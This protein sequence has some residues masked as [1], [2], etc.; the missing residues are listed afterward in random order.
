MADDKQPTPD[1]D[2]PEFGPSASGADAAKDGAPPESP[3]GESA[4]EAA[5]SG[6]AGDGTAADGEKQGRRKVGRWPMAALIVL[7]LLAAGLYLSWPILQSRLSGP[8]VTPQAPEATN[9]LDRRVARLEAADARR[10]QAVGTIKSTMDAFA[11][12]L[13]EL[14]QGL[15]G[16][17]DLAV[18][19]GKLTTMEAV[20]ARLGRKAGE[21][22]AAALA[23]LGAEVNV[24]RTRLGALAGQVAR[25]GSESESDTG[26]ANARAPVSGPSQEEVTALAQQAAALASDNK[27]LRQTLASLQA[28][29]EP[30]ERAVRQSARAGPKAGASEGLVLAV[31]QLHRTV[32]AGV[33]YT[34]ALAAVTALAGDD[35]ALQQ[36]ARTLAP[37]AGRGIASL[38]ALSDQFPGLTR[39]VLGAGGEDSDDFWRRTLHRFTSLVTVRRVGEVEGMEVDA[40]L[41]RAERRLAAGDLAAAANLIDGLDGPAATAARDWLGRAQAR[42]AAMAA[43]ADLQSR[44]IAALAHG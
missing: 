20:M 27:E 40:I 21:N 31:G 13:D 11:K 26:A 4:S 3:W 15:P 44:A 2:P 19:R 10:D 9:A 42:L 25:P 22:G 18:L 38:G 32:L 35:V 30:L 12:R 14:S 41:A 43:L 33:P 7:G 34:A 5:T 17:E 36:A 8:A 29:L 37:M 23:A 1:P 24:L 6:P 28:R 39:A 16:G